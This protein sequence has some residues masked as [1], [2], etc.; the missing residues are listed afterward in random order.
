M[1]KKYIVIAVFLS[2][3]ILSAAQIPVLSI[4]KNIFKKKQNEFLTKNMLD[5]SELYTFE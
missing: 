4:K 5:R 1:G 2:F 3:S